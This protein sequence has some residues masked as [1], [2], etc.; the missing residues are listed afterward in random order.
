VLPDHLFCRALTLDAFEQQIHSAQ[1][2]HSVWVFEQAE[3]QELE[4][5]DGIWHKQGRAVVPPDEDLRREI[6]RNAHDHRIAGHP[7]IKKTLLAVIRNYWWPKMGEFVTNYVKGCGVCQETKPGTAKALPPLVP[8]PSDPTSLPFQV[9]ALDLIIDLPP[10]QGYDSILTITDHDVSKAAVFLPCSQTI[11]G[12][13]VAALFATHVFPHFG[14]PRKVISDRDTRFTS[15]FT[16]ELLRILDVSKNMSTAYH[17][18]TDGQS[19]RTNQWLEQYLRIYANHQQDDWVAWLPLAQ[20]VHNSWPSSTTGFT[21]FELL[22]GFTPTLNIPSS[23]KSKLPAIE[24]RGSFLKQLRD[25]AQEAIKHAQQLILKHNQKKRGKR[26]FQPYTLGEKVWLEGT[27]LKLSHPTAKLA[28]RRYGPFTITKVISPV[29]YRLDLPP[30]WK[31]FSTFHASLLSPYRETIEHGPNFTEPP[32]DL[33]EG[34]EE[35]EV[36]QILGERN[37]GRWKKKQF[38]VKWKGYSTAHNSWEPEENVNAPELVKEY[39]SGRGVRVRTTLLNPG[40]SDSHSPMTP[41]PSSPK[42]LS[43]TELHPRTFSGHYIDGIQ[44]ALEGTSQSREVW[45]DDSSPYTSR[46]AR[47]AAINAEKH[48]GAGAPAQPEY[49]PDPVAAARPDADHSPCYHDVPDCPESVYEEEEDM[50]DAGM[51]RGTSDR[52]STGEES[53]RAVRAAPGDPRAS[54]FTLDTGDFVG[55]T[56]G[57]GDPVD[58]RPGGAQVRGGTTSGLDGQLPRLAGHPRVKQ[59]HTSSFGSPYSA[60]DHSEGDCLFDQADPTRD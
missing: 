2:A 6:L 5:T 49:P 30:S 23:V 42:R 32:P 22:M 58:L 34:H 59:P 43:S 19:E 11:T 47:T 14:V 36:E 52:G 31:I 17:P 55:G 60:Y 53:P 38:L 3:Q 57:G 10:S 9:I 24:E 33:I 20:F 51:A 46:E 13:G 15:A 18:Q 26:T 25:R 12:E 40:S 54:S 29:V 21:P 4:E 45:Y 16:T 41:R 48:A 35:Y 27:N 39:R 1:E 7:G 56:L 44:E 50:G 8:I 37:F 28:P